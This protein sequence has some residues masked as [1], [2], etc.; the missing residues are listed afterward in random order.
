MYQVN[1][2]AE[3]AAKAAEDLDDVHSKHGRDGR[4]DGAEEKTAGRRG[5]NYWEGP[6][7]D[8]KSR[9]W[10]LLFDGAVIATMV[11]ALVLMLG[12]VSTAQQALSA[13]SAR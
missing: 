5:G 12:Y 13:S 7:A 2:A 8:L 1:D 3:A 6:W 9:L 4:R 11:A 10:V